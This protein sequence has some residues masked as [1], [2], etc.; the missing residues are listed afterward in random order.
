MLGKGP[1]IGQRALDI[2]CASVALV[3]TMPIWILAALM[4][5]I[6]SPGPVLLRQIRIGQGGKPFVLWKLRTMNVDVDPAIHQRYV[7]QLIRGAAVSDVG[8]SKP[9]A[10][11]DSHPDLIMFG[12]VLRK[13]C[14]D[15]LPQ[16]IN[17][18]RG[19][20]SLVGPRPPLPYEVKE[21]LPWQR[22]RLDAMPGMT[23]LWQVSGK[24][25]LTF[26]EMVRLDIQYARQQSLWLN[27]RI[28]WR[29]PRAIV[30]QILAAWVS[31][32]VAVGGLDHA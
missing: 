7:A 24:N 6:V 10:K 13:L 8:N 22:S 5:K 16:L 21:Y 14:I 20:M 1:A 25:K 28:I 2:L 29:T 26:N 9:M 15:E 18:L 32:K 3:V 31:P 17:V 23:G 27:I 4:I 11:L 19:E 30:Q 12:N